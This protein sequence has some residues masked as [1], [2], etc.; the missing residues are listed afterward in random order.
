MGGREMISTCPN[1][2]PHFKTHINMHARAHTHASA[3]NQVGWK[4]GGKCFCRRR[5][6][7][8]GAE[9]MPGKDTE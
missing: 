5:K 9:Q 4:G 6:R 2:N 3:H 1:L 8:R 7:V